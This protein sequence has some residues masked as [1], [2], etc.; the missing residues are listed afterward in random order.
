M[1][2]Q[3]NLLSEWKLKSWNNK[4]SKNNKNLKNNNLKN[5]SDILNYVTTCNLSKF[6]T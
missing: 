6:Q 1:M 2:D 3:I 4:N 5:N